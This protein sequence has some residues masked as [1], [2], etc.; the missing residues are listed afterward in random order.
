MT[1]LTSVPTTFT[2]FLSFRHLNKLCYTTGTLKCPSSWRSHFIH[3]DISIPVTWQSWCQERKKKKKR[4]KKAR[5]N[6]P[7]GSV[8]K[9]TLEV[10]IW[11][12]AGELIRSH[13]PC[14]V[15]KTFFLIQFKKK[16]KT[17]KLKKRRNEKRPH[18]KIFNKRERS[19]TGK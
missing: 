12:L 4:L 1:I 5:R 3:S 17:E 14:A 19:A 6:F 16:K 18:Q 9:T 2:H 13:M 8:I 11:S 7:D 10:W 15:K